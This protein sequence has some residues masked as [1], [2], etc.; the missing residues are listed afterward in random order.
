MLTIL[1]MLVAVAAGSTWAAGPGDKLPAEVR[2]TLDH[3]YRG[4]RFAKL[5]PGLRR[6]LAVNDS[7][8][9]LKGDY[10]GDGKIDYAVNIVNDGSDNPQKVVILLGRSKGFEQHVLESGPVNTYTF[11]HPVRK[12]ETRTDVT[13]DKT[14]TSASEAIDVIYDEKAGVTYLFARDHFRRIISGD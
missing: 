3:D 7:P 10:D 11:L 9:W 6:L 14:Y 12:G 13:T 1:G 8:E 5:D 4:W 2:S